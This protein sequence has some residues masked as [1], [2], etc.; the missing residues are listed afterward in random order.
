MK[1][2]NGVA[3]TEVTVVASPRQ[4]GKAN[5]A[6]QND[7]TQSQDGSSPI[8]KGA[9]I[10][11]A[12]GA[13]FAVLTLLVLVLILIL[14][15]RRSNLCSSSSSWASSM[16]KTRPKE[17]P[18][19]PEH[20]DIPFTLTKEDPE[21]NVKDTTVLPAA[22]LSTYRSYVEMDTQ[23]FTTE[24]DVGT[25]ITE[26][27][28]EPTVVELDASSPAV[29]RAPKHITT[30]SQRSMQIPCPSSEGIFGCSNLETP[31]SAPSKASKEDGEDSI[32]LSYTVHNIGHMFDAGVTRD[33]SISRNASNGSRESTVGCD[34]WSR[35]TRT[36]EVPTPSERHSSVVSPIDEE[37]AWLEREEQRI[38]ERKL[39]LE[40]E[41]AVIRRLAE[42]RACH[43]RLQNKIEPF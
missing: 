40:Q 34:F 11:I 4:T 35:M 12:L 26:L 27:S 2:I 14:R 38:R 30:I 13:S 9:Q 10:G 33:G 18:Q 42:L 19:T 39:L 43:S 3:T 17:L 6:A 23:A 15:R 16:I 28:T 22:E 8:S 29:N 21:R 36:S 25:R 20:G 7:G 41:G 31:N 37:L 1:T 24:L 5:G 32:T